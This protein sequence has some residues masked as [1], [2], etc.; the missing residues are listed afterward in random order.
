M[1]QA[2][3]QGPE[4]LKGNQGKRGKPGVDA[5][6]NTY[7][8]PG[9]DLADKISGDESFML[10][11]LYKFDNDVDFSGSLMRLLYQTQEF[12]DFLS[13]YLAENKKT[14]AAV[15]ATMIS[16]ANPYYKDLPPG[17][18]D[19]DDVM[20]EVFYD[21][22]GL[23]YC[24]D[25]GTICDGINSARVP[26]PSKTS[27]ELRFVTGNKLRI[28][29]LSSD[30]NTGNLKMGTTSIYQ[31]DKNLV[32]SN[33]DKK[34]MLTPSGDINLSNIEFVGI[35]TNT[36][37]TKWNIVN[38][39][40]L[41]KFV[42]SGNV[43]G[44]ALSYGDF[45]IGERAKTAG[46]SEVATYS[47]TGGNLQV[48]NLT[49]QTSGNMTVGTLI[50]NNR[51]SINNTNV[52]VPVTGT[53]TLGQ[54]RFESKQADRVIPHTLTLSRNEGAAGFS[55]T[56]V[57][58]RPGTDTTDYEE[59]TIVTGPRTNKIKFSDN[60]YLQKSGT[61]AGLKVMR[62]ENGTEVDKFR[63]TTSGEFKPG[64]SE[65]IFTGSNSGFSSNK[66]KRT[67]CKFGAGPDTKLEHYPL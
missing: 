14:Q 60:W 13:G 45:I 7:L 57:I 24:Q 2:G 37:K 67:A 3:P 35:D 25:N 62:Q 63:I 40:N 18:I 6:Q 46:T 27:Q 4:G 21:V 49:I 17:K 51:P 65:D 8:P 50:V 52:N 44:R 19:E 41:I 53:L 1:G 33:N 9:L 58:E 64:K 11:L 5:K 54:W 48:S 61:P 38:E 10:S 30:E 20:K 29:G 32:F 16:G 22:T 12:Y 55:P 34:C 43:S 23:L 31:K 47:I 15:L 56:L 42:K 59:T 28:G 66:F 39:N 36:N 26:D